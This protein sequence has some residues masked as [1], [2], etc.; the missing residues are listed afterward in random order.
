MVGSIE[1]AMVIS[2]AEGLVECGVQFC[3][4]LN[5][6]VREGREPTALQE[7]NC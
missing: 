3:R 6:D 7:F 1:V 4:L 2:F 5:L